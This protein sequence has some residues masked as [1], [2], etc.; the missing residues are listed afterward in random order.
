MPLSVENLMAQLFPVFILDRLA[1]LMPTSSA[2]WLSGI[3][4][5]AIT[6]SSLSTIAMVSQRTVRLVLQNG[7]IADHEAEHEEDRGHEDAS[8][9][10]ER[11]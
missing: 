7:P 6:L 8:E 1:L 3:F 11:R 9:E 4:L 10:Q 5:S 2:N